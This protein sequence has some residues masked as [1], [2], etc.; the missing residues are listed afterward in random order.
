VQL[1]HVRPFARSP[2]ITRRFPNV[3]RVELDLILIAVGLSSKL[4]GEFLLIVSLRWTRWHSLFN[5]LVKFLS[6]VIMIGIP[7]CHKIS[8]RMFVYLTCFPV[9]VDSV[10]T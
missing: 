3:S 2:I 7:V 6:T 9:S 4:R 10:L 8:V 1:N 5:L